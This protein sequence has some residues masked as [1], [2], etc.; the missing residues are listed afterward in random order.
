MFI[1][2]FTT[3]TL[4]TL[5]RNA[6]GG[7]SGGEGSQTPPEASDGDKTPGSAPSGQDDVTKLIEKAVADA[8]A[9]L[10]R[11]NEEVI[12]DNKKLKDQLASLKAKPS[13]SDE[14]YTEFKTLK[15]RMERDE[16]LKALAEG[17]SEEVI[18]KVTRKTKIDY[19]AKL[20]A[21]AEA[22]TKAR[23]DALSSRR[24]LEQ[25][26]VNMEITKAAASTVKPPYQDLVTRLLADRVKLVDGA[27]RVVDADGNIEM[28]AN[29]SKP[30]AVSDLL[31]TLRGTYADLFVVS[32]GGG[33]AGSGKRPAGTSSKISVEAAGE[34]SFEDYARLRNEGKIG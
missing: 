1:R 6:E 23:E 26:L 8:V 19:E 27:V 22:T 33:A 17:K 30:L 9:G 18:D 34:M 13:L 2:G 10:K 25:T 29:G 16:L 5:Y 12:G 24:L 14:E 32:S 15:E 28:G 20:A 3:H 31:E 21:E 7:E 11:K 4:P